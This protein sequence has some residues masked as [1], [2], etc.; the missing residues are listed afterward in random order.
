MRAT[1]LAPGRARPAPPWPSA[2][3]T[4]ARRLRAA[5]CSGDVALVVEPEDRLH[6]PH[7]L[8]HGDL[9][10]RRLDQGRHEVAAGVGGVRGDAAHGAPDRIVVSGLLHAGQPVEL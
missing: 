1:T 6:R 8:A 7:G 10:L 5:P 3:A 9:V 4:D 2:P